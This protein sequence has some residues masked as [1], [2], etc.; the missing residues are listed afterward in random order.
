VR[1]EGLCQK[2]PVS[3]S[4]IEPATFR[5]VAQRL[6]Q[7]QSRVAFLLNK[8]PDKTNWLLLQQKNERTFRDTN[9]KLWFENIEHANI[10]IYKYVCLSLRNNGKPCYLRDTWRKIKV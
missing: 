9:K 3:L 2:I 4:G 8:Y 5:V 7:L 1:P 6:N 10:C